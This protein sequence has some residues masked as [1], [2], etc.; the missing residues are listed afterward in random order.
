MSAKISSLPAAT[1]VGATDITPVVQGGVN[2]S[3]TRDIFL[4]DVGGSQVALQGNGGFVGCDSLGNVSVQP[5]AG[6][7][8]LV[9]SSYGSL[10]SNSSVNGWNLTIPSGCNVTLAHAS[11]TTISILGSGQLF[12]PIAAGVSC[13]IGVGS[14]FVGA[15]FTSKPPPDIISAINRIA[16]A[17][18]GLLGGTIP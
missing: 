8:I 17:V 9:Q 12:I 3:Y 15:H 13:L 1:S 18:Q 16:A 10:T 4:T 11:G 6:G 2:M 7:Q 5:K 14:T